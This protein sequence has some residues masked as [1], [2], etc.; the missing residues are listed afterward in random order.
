MIQLK[1]KQL[2]RDEHVK[3][4]EETLS[5]SRNR[6]LD[7]LCSS[8]NELRNTLIIVNSRIKSLVRD[9]PALEV[10]LREAS[11]LLKLCITESSGF[12]PTL[13]SMLSIDSR[14]SL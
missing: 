11:S 10:E 5:D 2:P 9:N 4:E 13:Y 1:G 7:E 6:T 8:R 14:I 3:I 12:V